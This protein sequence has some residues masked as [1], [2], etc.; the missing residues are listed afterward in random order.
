MIVVTAG[1]TQFAKIITE[2]RKRCLGFGYDHRVYDLGGLGMGKPA[3]VANGDFKPTIEKRDLPPATFKPKLMLYEFMQGEINCWIDGDC[4][5]LMPFEPDGEWDAA[6]T[7]RSISEIGKNGLRAIDY[8]NSG[9]VWI[10]NRGFAQDW[11]RAS[12]AM[13]TDQDGLNQVVGP[14]LTKKQ[15]K[16]AMDQTITTPSGY[17]VK[18]LNAIQWNCWDFPPKQNT[19]ILHFKGR[20][21]DEAKAYL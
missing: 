17:S 1:T 6:V 16:S 21:R 13:N 20:F 10:R 5:P 15:W 12:S 19:K 8:L 18:I 7:L 3:K 11:K 4:L 14:Y 9:V 2:Q